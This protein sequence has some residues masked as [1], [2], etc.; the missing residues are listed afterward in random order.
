MIVTKQHLATVS[1]EASSGPLATP[2]RQAVRFYEHLLPYLTS[3]YGSEAK[4]ARRSPKL[5]ASTHNSTVTNSCNFQPIRR[6]MHPP[7]TPT[8][9]TLPDKVIGRVHFAPRVRCAVC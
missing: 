7:L 1:P 2:P 9:S 6:T 5:A 3:P 4:S 8:T